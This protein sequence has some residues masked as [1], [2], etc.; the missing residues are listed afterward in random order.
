M[1]DYQYQQNGLPDWAV[2]SAAAASRL[3]TLSGRMGNPITSGLKAGWHEM[4][5]SLWTAGEALGAA[6][7]VD[8]L[9]Q[10]GAEVAADQQQQAQATGRPDLEVAPWREGGGGL[11]TALPWLGYQAAKAVPSLVGMIAAGAAV[12][13]AAV[14]AALARLGTRV[15]AA[16]GG[17]KQFA[18]QAIGAT[19][20]GYPLGVAATAERAKEDGELTQGEGLAALAGGLPWA[21]VGAVAPAQL[22]S[23]AE[24]GTGELAS[25]LLRGAAEGAVVQGPQNAVQT[26]IEQQYGPPKSLGER[27]QE[28]IDSALTG[29]AVGGVM[30]GALNARKRLS[31]TTSTGE[32]HTT[33][34]EALKPQ[35][36]DQ[37]A[38]EPSI[39]ETGQ[40]GLPGVADR[41]Q[42][43]PASPEEGMVSRPPVVDLSALL[44]ARAP[45]QQELDLQQPRPVPP[46]V[47]TE[48]QIGL[49]GFEQPQVPGRGAASELPEPAPRAPEGEQLGLRFDVPLL[50][51][52]AA[53]QQSQTEK[54]SA[55]QALVE[56]FG[57]PEPRMPQEPEWWQK[58]ERAPMSR[59]LEA[60]NPT[61][62][63]GQTAFSFMRRPYAGVESAD[64][65]SRVEELNKLRTEGKL[66]DA[67]KAEGIAMMQ[68]LIQRRNDGDMEQMPLFPGEEAHFRNQAK[69]AETR[70]QLDEELRKD[71][72]PKHGANAFL[73]TFK[74]TDR[75]DAYNKIEDMVKSGDIKPGAQVLAENWGIGRD[76]DTEA[77]SIRKTW[78]KAM[79][80]AKV[81]G[82]LPSK[83]QVEGW[84]KALARIQ[85][86]N[87]LR[88]QAQERRM[89]DDTA[90]NQALERKRLKDQ[91]GLSDYRVSEFMKL[92]D[93]PRV[94][95][96]WLALNAVRD[97]AG[98]PEITGQ[99]RRNAQR[100]LSML[101]KGQRPA[102]AE[103]AKVFR[104][105]PDAVR[106]RSAAQVDVRKEAG[107]GPALGEGNTER[108]TAST[109]NEGGNAPGE[110]P[111]LPARL[112]D[113]AVASAAAEQRYAAQTTPRSKVSGRKFRDPLTPEQKKA[114]AD[115][116]ALKASARVRN[117]MGDAATTLAQTAQDLVDLAA[118]GA[119]LGNAVDYIAR[120]NR[121]SDVQD[122]ARALQRAR[123]TSEM[124][125]DQPIPTEGLRNSA[126]GELVAGYDEKTDRGFFK[127]TGDIV[128]DVLHEAT[129]A[130]T[131]KAI[132]AGTP[133]GKR[134]GAL[135]QKAREHFGYE[136]K[137]YGLTDVH[138]FIAEAMSNPQ[139]RAML[140][141]VPSDVPR[142]SVWERIKDT[143]FN[144]LGLKASTR[145]LFDDV[146]DA[147]KQ[148]I[149]QQADM[150]ALHARVDQIMA[151]DSG[152]RAPDTMNVA[153][154]GFAKKA[155]DLHEMTR[156]AL[157][158]DVWKNLPNKAREMIMGW[159]TMNHLVQ[160]MRDVVPSA[161]KL[162]AI[163]L[164]R[165]A[166][167]GHIGQMHAKG[168]IGAQDW[169]AQEKG[170]DQLLA[171]VMQYTAMKIDPRL[172]WDRQSK[173]LHTSKY[174]AAMKQIVDQ[175][176]SDFDRLRQRGGA[177]IYE[178][179]V[180]SAK[181]DNLM[182]M[183]AVLQ[184][185]VL[186][187]F[188]S[189]NLP[190]FE[191]A[192]ADAY[193]DRND[194]HDSPEASA[195]FFMGELQKRM[196]A[197]K[198]YLNQQS[199][200]AAAL[201]P[202]PLT[203]Q[204]GKTMT[205]AQKAAHRDQV[206][207]AKE[208]IKKIV[209]AITPT[210]ELVKA[211][212]IKLSKLDE[213]PNLHLARF[214]DYAVS[215]RLKVDDKGLINGAAI[216]KLENV[217][218][219]GGF[220]N[221][222]LNRVSDS[223]KLYI[224][225]E[226]KAQMEN[227]ANLLRK[228]Q[229][230]G[231]LSGE[232]EIKHGPVDDTPLME[233]VA[234]KWI[235]R[236]IEKVKGSGVYDTEG[237]S[238]AEAK[239]V[240][241]ARDEHIRSLRHMY[242]DVLPENS[243]KKVLKPRDAVSGFSSD[244]LRAHA[245]RSDITNRA[246]SQLTYSRSVNN[247][248]AMMRDEAKRLRTGTD[249]D[250]T[251]R[252]HQMVSE[253]MLR[254]AQKPWMTYN[255]FVDMLNAST[256]A[257]F[258]GGSPAYAVTQLSQIPM[259]LWPELAKR[260]G[261]VNS[262]KAIGR[263]TNTAFK[264]MKAGWKGP[265]K[266]DAIITPEAL[267]KQGVG[268]DTAR[269]ILNTI[270][271]GDLENG[272]FTREL[273]SFAKGEGNT[274]FTKFLSYANSMALY[275]E[276]YARVV[277]ALAARDLHMNDKRADKGDLHNYVQS[278]IKESMFLFN[279]WNNPRQT[280]KMG[281]L[282]PYSPIAFKFTNYTVQ[283]LEKFYR[284]IAGAAGNDAD[285]KRWLGGHLAASVMVAGTLGMPLAPMLAGVATKMANTLTGDDRYDF[286]AQYRNFLADTFGKDVGEVIAHGAPRALG[287]D[288]SKLGDQDL[289][290]FSRLLTDR[291][292]FEDAFADWTR[293]MAG[294]SVSMAANAVYGARDMMNG[295]YMNGMRRWVPTALRGSVDDLKIWLDGGAFNKNGEKLPVQPE[296]ISL[297]FKA[298]G[299]TPAEEAEYREA[300]RTL[301]G[302]QN[303][304]RE[305]AARVLGEASSAVNQGDLGAIQSA[306]AQVVNY[307]KDHPANALSPRLT[308]AIAAH[309]ER[310]TTAAQFRTPLGLNVQNE[311]ERRLTGFANF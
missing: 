42:Q 117:K 10:L 7:G 231:H 267:A 100:A 17:G 35:E 109:Q 111:A 148:A 292:K 204:Q 74:A 195:Q 196:D 183:A 215:A 68:E 290:P 304:R 116:V 227:L 182:Q 114:V 126:E 237:L 110:T 310:A 64:L 311:Q 230:D 20:A 106:E 151:G 133:A 178:N 229:A 46:S 239:K 245:R 260:H 23:F 45:E 186:G 225:V 146:M 99:L 84:K 249:Y 82:Q 43:A 144:A 77:A 38:P 158:A 5:G 164:L 65:R 96:T 33:V 179:L 163:Y 193:R 79:E 166:L 14:P 94:R 145:S 175:A 308:S 172:K 152:P 50:D 140:M 19:V 95:E 70:M 303:A 142:K 264:V 211:L 276:N 190:G 113:P 219:S 121:H 241:M 299:F 102:M 125:F 127:S 226:G 153:T 81:T 93:D 162:P 11:S 22:R 3:P 9:R 217:L 271:R 39:D 243:I 280:G 253:L 240:I 288:F 234:P 25:R 154:I 104:N 165:D 198:D 53:Y 268:E 120:S 189:A 257:Y 149:D 28:I 284:E 286:V 128:S 87:D 76:L 86:L 187:E 221:V 261:F 15:P 207:K 181:S 247:T 161:E 174:S 119:H 258:L 214:G 156:R 88:M 263:V 63:T 224:R 309:R 112:S 238:E 118:Q 59:Q 90:A 137:A 302:A 250:A 205:A 41:E 108:Q 167:V 1:A 291:R 236:M 216:D 200:A 222:V 305:R 69:H 132:E 44:N 129:H 143:V 54:Q 83:T 141:Q 136:N 283:M 173:E 228:A 293:S 170:N 49:P 31:P 281:V 209:D 213:A 277:A 278:T 180:W 192:P 150:Q 103:A 66:A 124:I 270:N 251:L 24:G 30:G 57:I 12:P 273:G 60:P 91:H 155:T 147:G 266:W 26:A 210:S 212:D 131:W 272:G 92:P 289:I 269:F 295:D 160:A 297:L 123:L 169:I 294:S 202:A 40:M 8:G 134:L 255:S 168:I 244:M 176:N 218:R 52:L 98:N 80:K 279:S 265:L 107:N 282:G 235:E 300:Q 197:V 242:M 89:S 296:A 115:A 287:L 206:E 139:F 58:G 307:D 32:L 13:E 122:F 29:G 37:A 275:T 71:I 298:L 157:D 138:E 201:K 301:S 188:G 34:D 306:M 274:K 4:L 18:R 135:Y 130:A 262:A 36:V 2:E 27:A 248:M 185:H 233:G 254:D 256:H 285:A 259:L 21:A 85:S 78:D 51:E 48:G 105:H 75:L 56:R 159:H 184:D 199:A 73:R 101:E 61:D 191:R 208:E 62:E 16:L 194:L 252:A 72:G 223:D 6:T 203:P 220:D 47:D 232:H 97:A 177:P 55:A 246:V 171:R 67:D